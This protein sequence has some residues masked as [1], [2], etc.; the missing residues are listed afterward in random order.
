MCASAKKAVHKG[1]N[2]DKLT[3]R[4]VIRVG[5]RNQEHQGWISWLFGFDFSRSDD[6]DV[7]DEEEEEEEDSLFLIFAS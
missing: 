2:I 5:E 7:E 3:S 1:L 6:G 4:P